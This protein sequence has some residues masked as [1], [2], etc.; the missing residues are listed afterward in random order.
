MR[1]GRSLLLPFVILA[2][3]HA[4]HGAKFEANNGML[5]SDV[6]G[7]NHRCNTSRAVFSNDVSTV[8]TLHA[9]PD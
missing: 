3:I 7:Q 6:G 2:T 5:S 4:F 1:E 9:A 8:L